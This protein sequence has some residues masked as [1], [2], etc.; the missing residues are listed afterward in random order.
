MPGTW[1][2]DYLLN[3]VLIARSDGEVRPIEALYLSRCRDQ[4]S[5]DRLTLADAVLRSYTDA[6]LRT[7]N[8]ITDERILRDLVRMAVIDGRTDPAEQALAERFIDQARLPR[9][10]VE[11]IIREA[12]VG[13][14]DERRAIHRTLARR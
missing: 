3:L 7:V 11:A 10:R 6:E 14:E 1:K 8:P 13:L 9:L 5:G 4:V 2:A 12:F